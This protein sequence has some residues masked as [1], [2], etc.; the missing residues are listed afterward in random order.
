MPK[1]ARRVR[2]VGRRMAPGSAQASNADGPFCCS[3]AWAISQAGCL[4]AYWVDVSLQSHRDIACSAPGGAPQHALTEG[5]RRKGLEMRQISKSQRLAN[6]AAGFADRGDV[7][8]PW[9]GF[10]EFYAAF[11]LKHAAHAWGKG[12]VHS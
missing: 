7:G 6:L 12:A 11:G 5:D 9:N 2:N 3:S 1:F 8:R 4:T 10:L